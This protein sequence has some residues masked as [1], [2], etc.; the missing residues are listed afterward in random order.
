MICEMAGSKSNKS[1][2]WT[3]ELAFISGFICVLRQMSL[4][5]FGVG[6]DSQPYVRHSRRRRPMT[7]TLDILGDHLEKEVVVRK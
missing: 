2:E 5:C 7:I 4:S 1:P 6:A 3:A